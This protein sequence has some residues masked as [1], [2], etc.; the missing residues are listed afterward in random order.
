MEGD[1]LEREDRFACLIHGLD[2]VFETRRGAFRAEVA[3]GI[4]K[5]A[6]PFGTIVV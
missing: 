4:Y 6:K 1:W 3:R 2:R 5:R